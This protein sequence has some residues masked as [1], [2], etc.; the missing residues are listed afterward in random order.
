M[1]DNNLKDAILHNKNL[2]KYLIRIP[3]TLNVND[4]IAAEMRKNIRAELFDDFVKKLDD[5]FINP[6]NA[7]A[8]AVAA[9]AAAPDAVASKREIGGAPTEGES[10]L[11]EIYNELLTNV[12]IIFSRYYANLTL[13]LNKTYKPIS[14]EDLKNLSNL[15]KS[16]FFLGLKHQKLFKSN[17]KFDY[18]ISAN[19]EEILKRLLEIQVDFTRSQIEFNLKLNDIDTYC[20]VILVNLKQLKKT[21]KRLLAMN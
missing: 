6:D 4:Q 13:K 18:P 12:I 8:A 9:P 15:E 20:L 16:G 10:K 17:T 5:S 11:I 14:N 21:M 7:P 2:K 1:A 3:E 19:I